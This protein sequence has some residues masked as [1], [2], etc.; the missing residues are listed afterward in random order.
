M[1]A[2]ER[3]FNLL[4]L[5]RQGHHGGLHHPKQFK[6]WFDDKRQNVASL[7]EA[8]ARAEQEIPELAALTPPIVLSDTLRRKRER[9]MGEEFL[10]RML[11]S[12]LVDANRLGSERHGSEWKAEI[13]ENNLTLPV[14]LARFDAQPPT[15]ASPVSDKVRA[16]EAVRDYPRV[17]VSHPASPLGED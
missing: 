5:L 4:T 14:L 8:I 1:L 10:L 11:F 17:A 6:V 2:R 3:D 15:P 12:A 9:E 16:A 7:R 13:H